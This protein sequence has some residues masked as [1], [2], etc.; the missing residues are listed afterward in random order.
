MTNG[1][2]WGS[3]KVTLRHNLGRPGQHGMAELLD[4]VLFNLEALVSPDLE[5]KTAFQ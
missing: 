3:G 2:L 1:L 5:F 4:G